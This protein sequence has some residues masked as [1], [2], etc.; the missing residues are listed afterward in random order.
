MDETSSE[1][2]KD[3][4][5]K[6]QIVKSEI[7]EEIKIEVIDED[8][9][10]PV[11]LLNTNEDRV[12]KINESRAEKE[13][14]IK[15]QQAKKQE[16][17][18]N[19]AEKTEGNDE[20]KTQEERDNEKELIKKTINNMMNGEGD[21][22][23]DDAQGFLSGL[24]TGLETGDESVIEDLSETLLK[25]AGIDPEEIKNFKGSEQELMKK[26]MKAK[27]SLKPKNN[28]QKRNNKRNGKTTK[29]KGETVANDNNQTDE[30][31]QVE[32]AKEQAK[33][34]SEDEQVEEKTVEEK[35]AEEKLDEQAELK[36]RMKSKRQELISK[37]KKQVKESKNSSKPLYPI[38]FCDAEKCTTIMNV[39]NVKT[40]PVCQSFHYCSKECQNAHWHLHKKMCGKNP[41]DEYKA[42]LALYKEAAFACESLYQHV[43]GGEYTTVIHEEG[44]YPACIFAT[45]ATAKSNVLN[46]KTY[47]KNSLFTTSSLGA[48]GSIGYKIQAAMD[49]LPT[50]K[51]FAVVCIFD[52]L[53]QGETTEAIIRI[54]HADTYGITMAAPSSG[55]ITKQ[56][57]KY[58]RK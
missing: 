44:N 34:D 33:E 17:L 35:M 42:R 8:N 3:Q 52:R 1:V 36:K 45:L 18:N 56:E 16:H 47:I 12:R 2:V 32:E 6:D 31:P 24:T 58:K 57:I 19:E 5:V 43:K 53:E 39:T 20:G 14:Q 40:C 4:I 25:G 50:Q 27:D 11:E 23:F 9:E 29:Q 38:F 7:K 15:E 49:R 46:W 41:S 55:K 21:K 13:Q 37:R 30:E 22:G 10:A 51:I 28:N 26:L 54:F 48:F